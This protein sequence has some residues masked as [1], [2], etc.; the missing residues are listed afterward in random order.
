VQPPAVPENKEDSPKPKTEEQRQQD[1]HTNAGNRDDVYAE[2]KVIEVDQDAEGPYVVI[3][4]RDG[5]MIVRL[6][7][8]LDCPIIRVGNYIQVAGTKEH[9]QLFYADEV[10]VSGR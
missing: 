5:N 10:D 8:G 9:E 4:S 3:G 6:L 7:C 2:G 1:Q